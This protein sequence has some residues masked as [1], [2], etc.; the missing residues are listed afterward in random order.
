VSRKLLH[1]RLLRHGTVLTGG[2]RFE[3]FLIDN[4]AK[5]L[6]ERSVSVKTDR[7]IF[8][9]LYRGFAHIT[10]LWEGFYHSRADVNIVT[11]RLGLPSI[12]RNLFSQNKTVIVL[13]NFDYNDGKKFYLKVYSKILFRVLRSNPARVCVI[14]VSPYFRNF[15]Q[16]EFKNLPVYKVPNLFRTENYRIAN[17]K[18][19]PKKILLGQYVSKNDPSVYDLAKMLSQK[20]YYCFFL[21][22]DPE[23][24]SKHEYFD[25]KCVSFEEYLVEMASS[26]CSVALTG[27]NEGWPR[28]VHESILVGTPVIGYAKGGLG[29]LLRESDSYIVNSAEEAFELITKGE[30][31]YRT[32]ISFIEKYDVSHAVEFLE[33]VIKFILSE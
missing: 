7:K 25:I 19:D 8:N 21:T 24:V 11:L 6:I 2:A 29:D 23:L 4:L 28:M 31:T 3:E 32:S 1:I 13:H 18:K 20:G 30:V 9:R 17:L 33:P 14:C 12:L 15:F 27:V 10:L 22:L 5:A 16:E 26:Y